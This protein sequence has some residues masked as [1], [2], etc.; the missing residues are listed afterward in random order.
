MDVEQGARSFDSGLLEL[1]TYLLHS[2]DA[3]LERVVRAFR[4]AVALCPENASYRA[5]LGFILDVAGYGNEAVVAL[6]EAHR[7]N[8]EDE[9]V[10]VL[11]AT[12]LAESGAETE[13]L[14]AVEEA[15]LSQQVDLT[16]LRQELQAAAMPTDARTLIANGFVH[17]RNFLR[18]RY[19]EEIDRARRSIAPQDAMRRAAAELQECRAMQQALERDFDARQ[20]PISFRDATRWASRIGIGDDVCRGIALAGLASEER[21]EMQRV[22]SDHASSIHAWLDG[23]EVGTMPPEAG[24]FMY[25]LL[26]VE[27]AGLGA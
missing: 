17:A 20:V 19:E 3:A 18:S 14:E 24:A 26:A 7:Q 9:E 4:Q 10:A 8:P 22:L 23:F 2:D 6:R 11:L 25:L 1:E 27:E 12:V 21:V 13:A 16:S 15:A 5:A